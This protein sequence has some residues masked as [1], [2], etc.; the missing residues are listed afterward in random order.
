MFMMTSPRARGQRDRGAEKGV[1]VTV[2]GA[3]NIGSHTI[4][5]VARWPSLERITIVDLGCY[6]RDNL[7]SQDIRP[8][9]VGRSKASVQAERITEL[10]PELSVD[11]F[12]SAVE[13][14]PL[15]RLRSSVILAC[16]DNNRARQTINEAAMRLGVPWIDAGVRGRGLLARVSV[17]AS[18]DAGACLEC[19]W[20]REDYDRLE[21]AHPCSLELT[22]SSTHAPPSLG[23]LAASLQVLECLKLFEKRQGSGDTGVQILVDAEHSRHYRTQFLRNRHCLISDHGPWKI[24]RF[25][26]ASPPTLEAIFAAFS[27]ETSGPLSLSVYGQRFARELFCRSC[28]RFAATLRLEVSCRELSCETCGGPLVASAV[29]EALDHSSLSE[30]ELARTS[31]ELGLRAGEVIRA[32]D[33]R[34]EAGAFELAAT[35]VGPLGE[36]LITTG[37]RT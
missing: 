29:A 15:G 6:E 28:R 36:E 23:A 12:E 9:D 5:Q 8:G 1:S 35:H 27:A 24:D 33:L 22:T 3:G 21:Q 2:V 30:N 34:G 17:Y 20:S 31:G 26:G 37:E 32:A 14:V 10:R 4:P 13:A 19:S 7:S 11:M 16:V 25:P 18:N